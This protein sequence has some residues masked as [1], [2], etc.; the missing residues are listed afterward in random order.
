MPTGSAPL[1]AP[2][3]LPLRLDEAVHH[4]LASGVVEIDGQFLT[5]NRYD[6]ARPELEMKDARPGVERSAVALP[7]LGLAFD[8]AAEAEA[9]SRRVRLP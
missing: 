7:P 6:R 2:E 5:V 3:G 8:R 9:A 1:T 4:E